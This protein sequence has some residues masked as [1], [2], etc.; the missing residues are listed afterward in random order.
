MSVE[1]CVKECVVINILLFL[2]V[3]SEKIADDYVDHNQNI[4]NK[5]QP[6]V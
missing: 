5:S 3:E 2:L 4:V 1:N 6:N